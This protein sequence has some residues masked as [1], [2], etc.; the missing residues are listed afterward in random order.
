M[1]EATQE[2]I[3]VLILDESHDAKKP[4]SKLNRAIFHLDY[5]RILMLT[6]TPIHNTL[7]DLAGQT[8][9]LPGRG[10]FTSSDHFSHLFWV[11]C[12]A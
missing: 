4:T 8:M 11:C 10:F 7:A 5:S 6:G 1:G 3:P 2:S 9:L 12:A